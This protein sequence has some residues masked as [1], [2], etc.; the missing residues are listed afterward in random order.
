MHRVLKDSQKQNVDISPFKSVNKFTFEV[1]KTN[2]ITELSK[3]DREIEAIKLLE[4]EYPSEDFTYEDDA[5]EQVEDSEADEIIKRAMIEADEILSSAKELAMTI[6]KSAYDEGFAKGEKAGRDI[7]YEQ[8]LE[9]GI[10]NNQTEL[11][12]LQQAIVREV[13]EIDKEKERI[14]EH[15]VVDLENVA[16]TIGEKIVQTSLKSSKD[17]IGRMILAAT[18]KMKKVAWAKIYI[19]KGAGAI[20][21]QGDEQFLKNLS[22]LAENVKIVIME[23]EEPGTCIIETSETILDISVKTQLDNIKEILNN[24]RL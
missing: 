14:L 17:V 16:L 4:D 2:E 3:S 13:R 24:A 8:A 10:K 5:D 22:R 9:I 12:K 21:I 11:V 20:D 18:E 6:K 23:D 15:Y 1:V 7:G 19:S